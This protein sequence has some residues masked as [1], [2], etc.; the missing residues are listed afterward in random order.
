MS[1]RLHRSFRCLP[2]QAI[3]ILRAEGYSISSAGMSAPS[4]SSSSTA[5][6]AVAAVPALDNNTLLLYKT[7]FCDLP[8]L[9]ANHLVCP[10]PK[11]HIIGDAN[12]LTGSHCKVSG[13]MNIIRGEFV[14]VNG[15]NNVLEGNHII[16]FG[17]NNTISKKDDEKN[18]EIYCYPAKKRVLKEKAEEKEENSGPKKKKAKTGEKKKKNVAAKPKKA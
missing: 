3:A 18:R 1:K 11:V 16:S 13:N 6:A 14:A 17:L 15:N 8:R 10:Q 12:T 9:T 7:L 4:S 2:S 5:A